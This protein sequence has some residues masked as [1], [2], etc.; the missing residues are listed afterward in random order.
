MMEQNKKYGSYPQNNDVNDLPIEHKQRLFTKRPIYC[1]TYIS[2]ER[3]KV[4]LIKKSLY[5]RR[6][7]SNTRNEYFKNLPFDGD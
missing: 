2:V 5:N 1:L 4:S 7:E 6:Y 3:L